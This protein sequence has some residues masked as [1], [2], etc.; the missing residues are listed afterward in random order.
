MRK[1]SLHPGDLFALKFL[2]EAKLSPG[3]GRIAYV[4]SRTPEKTAEELFEIAVRDIETGAEHTVPHPGRASGPRWAPDGRRFAF[5]GVAGASSRIFLYNL[6]TR[7][8]SALTPEQYFV[9]GP[10]AWSPDGRTLVYAVLRRVPEDAAQSRKTTRVFRADGLGATDRL[11]VLLQQVDVESAMVRSLQ[12]GPAVAVRPAFS[13]CGNRILFLGSS[14]AAGY[15]PLSLKAYVLDPRDGTLVE[16]TDDRWHVAAAAWSACGESIVIAGDRDSALAVPTPR[17]WVVQADGSNPVCRSDSAS[18]C[19]GVHA[20]HDMPTWRTS[21]S[22]LFYVA[23][24]ACAYATVTQGGCA[25]ICRIALQGPIRCEPLT[26]GA[27]TCVIFDVDQKASRLLYGVSDVHK[28]WDLFS[29]DVG[30]GAEVSLTNLN[31]TVLSK[32][33]KL[34]TQHLAFR[35]DD[36]LALEGWCL[37]RADTV[38]PLPAVLFIHG[39]PEL[40]SGH[41]FRFDFHLLAANGYAVVFS[42]F[43]GSSGYGTAFREA[44]HGNWGPSGFPDHMAAADAAIACAIADP[45]RLGLWGPSHG[46]YATAWAACHSDRF[47]AVV[48]E[49]AV[50]NLTTLYYLT[51]MPDI[52]VREFGGRPDQIPEVYQALS[53][54]THAAR[55]RT[56]TLMIHGVE[57]L[58]CPISEAEQFYRA[59]H[60]AGCRTELVRIA[61]MSHM[62]DSVGPLSAR[63]TQ[64]EALLE[65]FERHL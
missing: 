29:M 6:D 38:G 57:D 33:P 2:H 43:R 44:L 60:D 19:L 49:S 50:T 24:D 5:V 22:E 58:R 52:F 35:S 63:L 65:W 42:N 56:P 61:G 62:G 18:S 55:C 31:D 46:G 34:K 1:L 53:P 30:T 51:D 40:V 59:L 48:V 13:P 4:I 25:Q 8:L 3:G 37:T 14:V 9:H 26:A 23:E 32:W 64:N 21:Q 10:P 12:A 15:P 7:R 45:S 47:R 28:P 20:H 39:G 41:A 16:V 11:E 27:R 54:L 17:L 36:G